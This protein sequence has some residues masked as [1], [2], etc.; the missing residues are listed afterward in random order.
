MCSLL[1]PQFLDQVIEFRFGA[2]GVKARVRLDS[3]AK[4]AGVFFF[5]NLR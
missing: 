1:P 5:A 2:K 4:S 3:A